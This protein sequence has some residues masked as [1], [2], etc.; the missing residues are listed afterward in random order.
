[1]SNIK[2]FTEEHSADTVVFWWDKKEQRI[3]RNWKHKKIQGCFTKSKQHRFTNDFVYIFLKTT[4][5]KRKEIFV[6]QRL[7]KACIICFSFFSLDEST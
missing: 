6:L 5:M 7:L 3:H 1:M 2:C 4:V